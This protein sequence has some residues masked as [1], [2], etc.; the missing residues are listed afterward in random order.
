MIDDISR[1]KKALFAEL[2]RREG[3]SGFSLADARPK[4]EPKAETKAGPQL[5]AQAERPS[6]SQR[7]AACHA[8]LR[9]AKGSIDSLHD[10][11]SSM[12]PSQLEEYLNEPNNA[13]VLRENLTEAQAKL[14][15]IR[16]QCGDVL[17]ASAMNDL[18]ELERKLDG[19]RDRLGDAGTS[20]FDVGQFA[21]DLMS[22]L[23]NAAKGIAT[24]IT[25]FIR[26]FIGPPQP[27]SEAD[28]PTIGHRGSGRLDADHR[29]SGRITDHRGSGRITAQNEGVPPASDDDHRGSGRFADHR[30]SGRIDAA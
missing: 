23:G 27:Q 4:A 3:T 24:A 16:D 26:L 13:L 10:A 11:F 5:V 20:K 18:R 19:L 21:E 28:G 25:I 7:E 22:T 2:A 9:E 8:M 30:G 12:K 29:G 6:N 1:V 15:T 17:P 14:E